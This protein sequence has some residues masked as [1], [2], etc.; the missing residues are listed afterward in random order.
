MKRL[1]LLL[2]LLAFPAH[3]DKVVLADG[4]APIT[5]SDPQVARTRA[6]DEAFR[7]ATSLLAQSLGDSQKIAAKDALF[8]KEILRR[9]RTY[10]VRFKVKS[11]GTEGMDYRVKIEA[12]LSE[13]KLGAD[14]ELHGFA[15]AQAPPPPP[16]PPDRPPPTPSGGRPPLTLVLVTSDGDRTFATFGRGEGG[17]GPAAGVLQKLVEGLGFSVKLP[18]GVDLPVAIGEGGNAPIDD[19]QATAAAR[20]VGAG[21]TLHGVVRIKDGGAIRGTPLVGAEVELALAALDVAGGTRLWEGRISAAGFGPDLAAASAAALHQA[22]VQLA[23]QLGPRLAV[24]W[25]PVRKGPA[26][27]V[28]VL[29]R[30]VN[31]WPALEAAARALA[32]V[33]GVKQVTARRFAP[34]EV[35]LLCEGGAAP[36]ALA[37]ALGALTAAGTRFVPQSAGGAVT[38][39]LVDAPPPDPVIMDG[40][41]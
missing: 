39:D 27:G 20:A 6:L 37:D 26:G 9:A 2:L 32:A 33:P 34:T 35:T 19:A 36:R 38:V 11:E 16:P 12:L 14:L 23:R 18:A 1:A 4:A 21:G 15:R 22:E 10:V 30:G 41:Q 7:R 31:R 5:G 13:Q 28:E 17:P 3:A 29:F 40:T 8:Q 25:P 24:H